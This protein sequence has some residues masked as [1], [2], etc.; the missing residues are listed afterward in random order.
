[1]R[2]LRAADHKAMPWKNGG[3][4]TR[5][6]ALAPAEGAAF[7]WR[8]SLATIRES[9]PF[10]SFAGIDRTIVALRGN[11]VDLT[12]DGALAT[13][14]TAAGEPFAFAGEAA[15][16]AQVGEG[17]TTDLNIM[18]LRG[19]ARHVMKRLAWSGALRLTGEH[20]TTA[21]VFTGPVTVHASGNDH[22]LAADDAIVD[23]LPGETLALTSA[24]PALVYL[25]GI[26]IPGA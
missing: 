12:V 20:S 19:R 4:V 14:L 17:E 10:S 6:V 15:V 18:T 25:I 23:L 2:I 9:G 13:R 24:S 22:A 21:L 26:D 5:E 3:G 11:A 7:L 1:M 8:L 16:E